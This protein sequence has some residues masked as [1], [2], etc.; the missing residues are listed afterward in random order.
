MH[1]NFWKRM[2]FAA[3]LLSTLVACGG[4]GSSEP[5]P[6][7][8][9]PPVLVPLPVAPS[10]TQQPVTQSIAAGGSATFTVAASGDAPIGYQWLRN[11]V[12]LAAATSSIFTLS[13]AQV[14]DDGSI[15][16]ARVSNAGGNVLSAGATLTVKTGTLSLFAGNVDLPGTDDGLGAAARFAFPGGL[17]VDSAGNVFVA[18]TSHHTIRKISPAGVVST[19]AGTAYGSGDRLDGTGA[20]ATFSYPAG[21]AIDGAD[22]LYL[23]DGFPYSFGLNWNVVRKITPAAVT[24]GFFVPGIFPPAIGVDVAGNV[25]LTGARRVAPDGTQSFFNAPEARWSMDSLAVDRTGNIF[26]AVGNTI[27]RTA[28]GQPE[29]ILAGSPGSPPGA[30]DGVADQARFNFF[31]TFGSSRVMTSIAVD[32]KGNVYVADN[33]NHLVRRVTPAGVVTTVA[34]R[35][36]TREFRPGPL[37]GQVFEPRGLAVQGDKVLYVTSGNAVLK[38][39]LP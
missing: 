9:P 36:G 19:F 11:G 2:G 39:E 5:V 8:V 3:T 12:E 25:Y 32:G 28:P 14:S 34:G 15:W 26:Y 21:L 10:I 24:S 13:N 1:G 23:V 17:A 37:P 35:V 31:H 29:V 4:G 27:R 22:N 6:V 16:T 33:G 30:V 38:I 18:D 7:P 20:A